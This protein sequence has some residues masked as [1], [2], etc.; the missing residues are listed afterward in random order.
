MRPTAVPV[1][2]LA[3]LASLSACRRTT[4]L[5]AVDEPRTTVFIS[6]DPAIRPRLLR[7][8]EFQ[9]GATW[10]RRLFAVRLDR[11]TPL[12]DS[13]L[14]LDLDFAIP[15]ELRLG[16]S[17]PDLTLAARVNGME[18]CRQ[19]YRKH[20]R[21]SLSCPIPV[22]ALEHSSLTVEFETDRSFRD[23]ISGADRSLI[24]AQVRLIP[25]EATA[26]FHAL[27]G[28]RARLAEDS[29]VSA[30]DQYPPARRERLRRIM[31]SL[32]AWKDTR[33]L[34]VRV[35]RN[36]LDLWIIQQIIYEVRPEFVVAADAGEGGVALY[37]AR[38]LRGVRP[39][40]KVIAV[41]AGQAP[42]SA[43]ALPLWKDSVEFI[44]EKPEQ[45]A[46]EAVAARV[47]G[48]RTL[49]VLSAG[50]AARDL[51]AALN[52]YAALVSGGS[53]LILEDAARSAAAG[54]AVRSFLASPAASAFQQDHRRDAFLISFNTGG[55]LRKSVP[56][57]K[58]QE[59]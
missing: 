32:D 59:P 18:A 39:G 16:E 33:F 43:S 6:N 27:Q 57:E 55:W 5:A 58:E 28:R 8:F 36:P 2:T 41:G 35:G 7:G 44:P 17:A 9:P 20:G 51:G 25:Y 37:L 50:P 26:G 48:S 15:E 45:P 23:W 3:L 30:W 34:G 29:A 56:V 24:V 47:A 19:T 31:T 4:A 52:R 21:A 53:Y 54:A 42:A 13:P 11:P 49:V 22:A 14:Y 12:P 38:V 46:A 1:C 10:T 40:A